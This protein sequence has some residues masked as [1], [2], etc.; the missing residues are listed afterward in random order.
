ME[1]NGE[2]ANE[3]SSEVESFTNGALELQCERLI[4]II[5]N[6][7]CISSEGGSDDGCDSDSFL[8]YEFVERIHH[9]ALM[10]LKITLLKM[11]N[12]IKSLILFVMSQLQETLGSWLR[13]QTITLCSLQ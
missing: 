6:D 2:S 3:S 4:R 11:K 13:N 7:G 10:I 8:P 12:P 9:I 5:Q 1:K